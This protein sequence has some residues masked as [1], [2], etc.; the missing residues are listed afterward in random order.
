MPILLLK[1]I[2]PPKGGVIAGWGGVIALLGFAGNKLCNNLFEGINYSASPGI[3]YY[4]IYW[5]VYIPFPASPGKGGIYPGRGFALVIAEGINNL[6]KLFIPG[7]EGE[8][9]KCLK[10]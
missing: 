10:I 6:Y 3:N 5:E 7:G 8:N 2:T 9:N 1:E 4:I